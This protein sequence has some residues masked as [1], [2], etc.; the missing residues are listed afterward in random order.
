MLDGFCRHC[1]KELTRKR[2]GKR[3]E[4]RGVF[5]RRK[6]CDRSCM[7]KA[8]EGQIKSPTAQN[9]RRQSAKH[10]DSRCASCGKIKTLLHNHHVDAD[11]MRNVGSNLETLCVRCHTLR[12]SPN[13]DPTTGQRLPCL[14]CASPSVKNRMCHTHISRMKR[15]GHP[16]AKKIKIGSEWVLKILDG[17]G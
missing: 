14:Y 5:S 13:C 11:P 8:Y 4:D 16:L 15:H 2:F 9:S 10:R 7:A 3:L 1:G 12:H 6:F 17:N